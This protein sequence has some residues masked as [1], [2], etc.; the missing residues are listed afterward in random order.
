MKTLC[1]QISPIFSCA[2]GWKWRAHW[3]ENHVTLELKIV[4]P[5][6]EICCS[7]SC[8]GWSHDS[9]RSLHR[10]TP[11]LASATLTSVVGV[12][13]FSSALKD[14]LFTLKLSLKLE[15]NRTQS[16]NRTI[17]HLSLLNLGEK[18]DWLLC[19]KLYF[20]CWTFIFDL[21]KGTAC[22]SLKSWLKLDFNQRQSWVLHR[23]WN[24]VRIMI[25][26]CILKLV[27]SVKHFSLLHLIEIMLR[28]GCRRM[29][30]IVLIIVL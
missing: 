14:F 26:Y 21:L 7:R 18:G 6:V 9:I 27:P 13:H 30:D 20:L 12:Q 2:L 19:F 10:W 11:Q 5:E 15:L 17:A 16:K 23:K 1:N 8:V 28:S 25:S 24:P 22:P 29:K 3:A 4:W